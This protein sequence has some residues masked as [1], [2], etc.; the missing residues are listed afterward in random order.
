MSSL[1]A[2][3]LRLSARRLI[4]GATYADMRV[5]DSAIAPIDHMAFD[6]GKDEPFIVISTEDE[7]ATDIDGRDVTG[8]NRTIDLVIEVAIAHAVAAQGPTP[9]G[10]GTGPNIVIPATDSGFEISLGLISRQIMRALFEQKT[11]PWDA[12]FK[13]FCLSVDKITNKR[14]VGANDEARFAA[15]QIV[16]TIMAPHE[17]HFGHDPSPGD[18]WA[19]FL[20]QIDTDGEM[21]PLSPLI[22]QSITGTPPIAPPDRARADQGLSDDAAAKIGITIP[23]VP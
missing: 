20:T 1:V 19:D 23:G 13:R 22:R 17:P 7:N 2:M 3:A 8:G 14:G 4:E 12:V 11:N 15:R 16:I 9:A 18:I 21:A 5:H 10:A 6:E